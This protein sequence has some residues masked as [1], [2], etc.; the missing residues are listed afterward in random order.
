MAAV[1]HFSRS[2]H[3]H[4]GR[5]A[6]SYTLQSSDAG[7]TIRVV[8]TAT[9]SGG[10][11]PATSAQTGVVSSPPVDTI[12]PTTSGTPQ[13]GTTVS[14]TTG[15]W[16]G[17][18]TPSITSWYDCNAGCSYKNLVGTS[19]NYTAT[20]ADAG[21]Y[22]VVNVTGTNSAGNSVVQVCACSQVV[23][24][25]PVNTSAPTISGTSQVG[26]TL[27]AGNGVWS[28]V[29]APAF[30]YAWYACTAGCAQAYLQS[31][32]SYLTLSENMI[33]YYPVLYVTATNSAGS[34]T[35]G[36]SVGAVVPLP[37]VNTAAPCLDPTWN[38]TCGAELEGDEVAYVTT[39][40]W[41]NNPTSLTYYWYEWNGENWNLVYGG[42]GNEF[43]TGN[44]PG[45]E[46]VVWVYATNAGGTTGAESNSPECAYQTH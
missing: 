13:V 7:H 27:Y 39:G 12:A 40:S 2:L 38:W 17:T 6:S 33:V 35:A 26:Q 9:N 45:P 44:C 19:S 25:P 46:Y 41:T 42:A 16:T 15:S 23:A 43:R 22:L 30:T 29:P 4:L 28:G 32:N 14:V 18:P 11:T 3:Q 20:S 31:T 34:A 1:Q 36:T 37:P 10:S 24:S 8:V 21:Y 5:N